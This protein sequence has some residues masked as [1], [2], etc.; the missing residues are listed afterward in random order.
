M[1]IRR[2][3]GDYLTNGFPLSFARMFYAACNYYKTNFDTIFDV[4]AEKI[5][6]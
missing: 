3:G 5:Y 2:D 6:I 1:S 4:K